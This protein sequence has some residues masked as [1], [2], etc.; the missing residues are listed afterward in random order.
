MH[1]HIG[2]V[3]GGIQMYGR[4]TGG[5]KMYRGC[6]DVWGHTDLW[7]MYWAC[8]DV[9]GMYR[10]MGAYGHWEH[11]DVCG[12]IQ[13]YRGHTDVLG[14]QMY[15]GSDIPPYACLLDWVLYFIKNLSLFHI[16]TYC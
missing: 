11:T 3:L 6:T 2:D 13:M 10:C 9:W 16:G 14:V 8:T 1:R 12:D 15:K 4:C 7:G 5:I